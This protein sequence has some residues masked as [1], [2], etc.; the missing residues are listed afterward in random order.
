MEVTKKDEQIK[1]LEEEKN[2]MKSAAEEQTQVSGKRIE[3]L[4]TAVEVR[5]AESVLMKNKHNEDLKEA[6]NET[7]E[8]KEKKEELLKHV[9]NHQE[10]AKET[11]RIRLANEAAFDAE[12]EEVLSRL[13]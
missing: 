5:N 10:K 7:A 4:E 11:E 2:T 1:L 8:E 6:Q 9:R 13:S 3:F 12:T